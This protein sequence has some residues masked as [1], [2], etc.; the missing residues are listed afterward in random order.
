MGGLWVVSLV[1]E[2]CIDDERDKIP[3][4]SKECEES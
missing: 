2:M 1:L 4:L 3:I